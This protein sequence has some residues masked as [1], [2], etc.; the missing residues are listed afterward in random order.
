MAITICVATD[1]HWPELARVDGRGFGQTYTQEDIDRTRPQ[2][3]LHRFRLAL[4]GNEIVGVAGSFAMDVTLPGGTTVPMGGVTWVSVSSTHRRQGILRQLMGACHDDID[5]R[6]EPVASLGATESAI[7]ERFGYGEATQRRLVRI[8][9]KD[10]TMRPEFVP[11]QGSVRFMSH[12]DAAIAVPEM[13]D[14]FRRL[15]TGEVSRDE[16]SHDLILGVWSKPRG[17]QSE[18][19]FIR[20]RDG[21]ASYRISQHW[22]GGFPEHELTLNE[23]VALTPEAHAALWHNLVTTDLVGVIVTSQMPIDDRLPYMLANPR[24]VRTVGLNDGYWVN[25]RDVR[26]AFGARTYASAD[27]LVIEVR[28]GELIGKR[29]AI[30]GGPMGGTCTLVRSRP[31]LVASHASLGA[32]LYGGVRPSLLAAGGR[33]TARNADVLRR[34]DLFMTTSQAPHCQT[35]Y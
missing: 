2:L 25:V 26:V 4:D 8:E 17:D 5:A 11:P 6:G 22:N 21:Y 29:Y 27:R 9:T 23:M 18:G 24:A 16:R 30:D 28:D 20:H 15:R 31:D 19:F 1:D 32:M 14:R 13:W 3:D 33:L 10:A 34:A 7:Y 12:A 35:M